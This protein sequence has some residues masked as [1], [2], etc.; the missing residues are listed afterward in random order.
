MRTIAVLCGS[1]SDFGQIT[2]GLAVLRVAEARGAVKVLTVEVCSAHRN[3]EELKDLL[4][5][6]SDCG[7]DAVIVCA[8]KLAAI[9]GDT[10][11]ISRNVYRNNHTCFIAVPIRGKSEEANRAAYLSAK[12]VPNAQFVFRDEFFMDPTTAFEYAVNGEFPE[13]LLSE[14]KPP[15]TFSL[16]G[17]YHQGR[18]KYPENASVDPMIQQL[19]SGGL[20]HVSTGKTR[21]MFVNPQ[22][23]DLLLLLATDRVSI[24]DIV[25]NTTIPQKGAVLTAMTIHWL[26]KVFQDVPNHLLAYGNDIVAYL[27]PKLCSELGTAGLR[28]FMEN[29]I[30]VKRTKVLKIEA[31]VRGYLTGSG[32][33]DYR[34]SGSVCGVS[35]PQG[36][37][38]GS[39]LPTI[40]FT[41]S[42]K[43]DYG[44]HDENISF[45]RAVEIVGREATEYVRN[46]AISL[47]RRAKDRLAFSGI[48]LA[49]TKFEFGYSSSGRGRDLILI[50]E[51][52]TPDSSRFWPEEGRKAA[53]AEGRTPPSFDKEVIRIPGRAANVKS[54]PEWIPPQELIL[55]TTENY[56]RMVEL[57]TGKSLEQFQKEDMG[58]SK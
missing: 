41:P 57:A 24:F 10:D 14:Q 36:L 46:M 25:L 38:D 4:Y 6:F 56:R 18:R 51:V 31:I 23:P 55:Q 40:L 7:V 13:I 39:E 29:M 1:T 30:V 27:P 43:A 50:D 52:L 26:A 34:R 44:Q 33:T 20:I 2:S 12:E 28:L 58:I 17:A 9:F 42:T 11:A 16:A 19:E 48:T 3:P 22:Y 15:Q 32:L 37:V 47:Y 45:E 35:L 53:M 5:E 54:N 21:E 8:G 49:D